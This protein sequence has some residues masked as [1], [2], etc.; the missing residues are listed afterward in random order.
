MTWRTFLYGEG[1]IGR[2]AYLGWGL[3]LVLLKYN[4]DRFVL[5]DS[6]RD[7]YL[8]EPRVLQAYLFQVFPREAS[9]GTA[10]LA[11][12]LSIPF[13][14][15]GVTL[16]LARL[17]SAVL[18]L[19]MVGLFFVPVVKLALFGA[20]CVIP[21]RAA[22]RETRSRTED[23]PP[24][25]LRWLPGRP[26]SCGMVAATF[27]AGTGLGLVYLSTEWFRQYGWALFVATPFVVG[28]LAVLLYG[29]CHPVSLVRALGIATYANGLVGLLLLGFALEGVI[30]L[31]MAAPLGFCLGAVGGLAGTAI[32]A[33]FRPHDQTAVFCAAF[34]L[35][36]TLLTAER[37]FNRPAPLLQV[38]TII[39]IDAPPVRVW[40]QVVSFSEL[41]EPDEWLFR[42]GIAYPIRARIEGSGVGAVRY[43]EFSTGPFV[44]PIQVWDEPRLL[45]FSVTSNPAPLEEW[46]PYPHLHPAH[47]DGFLVSRQGQ[48]HLQELPDGRTR[49][50]G[51]TWYQHHLW[52]V[53]Y[54]QKWSDFIIHQIHRRV[55]LH[56][57]QLAETSG[58][59]GPV[60]P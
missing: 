5:S 7:W 19:W 55:L 1:K 41:P 49:L 57:K 38:R 12:S 45:R 36:P 4:L 40:P 25:W 59:P 17:R 8:T 46:T 52:P 22:P 29:A 39:D 11:L 37:V 54:W 47:L 6:A 43:C 23:E 53:S 13:V 16:T 56:I 60:P 44:E 30:C 3:A 34:L 42:V 28:L 48:F 31:I 9:T 24:R 2:A 27:A 14:W 58:R 15:V 18:P 20:L 10:A 21:P 51:T 33:S 32:V 50:E 26:L 35:V